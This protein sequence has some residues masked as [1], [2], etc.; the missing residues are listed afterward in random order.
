LSEN[1]RTWGYPQK[2]HWM[3]KMMIHIGKSLI[4][5]AFV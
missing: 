1:D 3:E 5:H 2:G 4:N